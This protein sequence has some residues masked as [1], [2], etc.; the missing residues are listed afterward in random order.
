QQEAV[1]PVV[2][3]TNL[4]RVLVIKTN[5]VSGIR[6]AGH[7]KLPPGSQ[8]VEGYICVHHGLVGLHT[9]ATFSK[10][11]LNRKFKTINHRSFIVNRA[12]NRVRYHWFIFATPHPDTILS[13]ALTKSRI[14][15][16]CSK[17]IIMQAL[18]FTRRDP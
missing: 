8:V 15:L 2:G 9:E 7:S 14:S 17:Y 6:Q 5:H 10:P 3:N 11:M 1:T 13:N 12:A 4:P 18:P 16:I